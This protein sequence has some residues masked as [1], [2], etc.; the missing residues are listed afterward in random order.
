M[1]RHKSHFT[2]M[3]SGRKSIGKSTFLNTLLNL[4]TSSNSDFNMYLLDIECEGLFKKV[5]AID[6]PGLN[7]VIC[8][9]KTIN[10][11]VKFIKHQHDL[12][13][14]EETKVKRDPHFEDSRVH[15]LIYFISPSGLNEIDL[16]FLKIVNKLVNVLPVIGKG[17]SLN[18]EEELELKIRT[19]DELRKNDISCFDFGNGN[20]MLNNDNL[21]ERMPL[22]IVSSENRM[23]EYENGRIEIDNPEHCDFPVLKEILFSTHCESLIE[24]TD[25]EIYEKYRTDVLSGLLSN[26]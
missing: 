7:A 6:T 11:I 24:Q 26:N 18:K 4:S 22:C 8:D 12:Y 23:R 25:C 16:V 2:F 21:W 17:D 20:G 10:D 9:S 5:T 1:R 3:V 19:R 14:S 15:C 13:L